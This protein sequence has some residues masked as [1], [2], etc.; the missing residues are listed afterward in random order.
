LSRFSVSRIRKLAKRPVIDNLD[1]LSWYYH[2]AQYFAFTRRYSLDF[3]GFIPR[4]DLVAESSESLANSNNYRPYS[5][6]HL[7]RLLR[8]ALETGIP[9]ES[10]VDVGCGKG[11]PCIFAKKYFGFANV[12]GIDF[13][14]PLIEVAKRNLAKTGYQNVK[15]LVA[16]AT[17]WALP[18]SN[19]LVLLNNPF[20]EIILE[21]F[22]VS[23]LD[24]FRTH[25]SLIAYGNDSFRST[26]CRLGF[27]IIFRSNRHR[28]SILQYRGSPTH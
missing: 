26:M 15:F 7:T 1:A 10:F 28:H 23:N 3:G 8:E 9:F 12:Y 6:F 2:E 20:N 5:N 4:E 11:H 14:E 27:E 16:D 21:K 19:T 13:C 22:L 17:T 25:R 18:A 24:H